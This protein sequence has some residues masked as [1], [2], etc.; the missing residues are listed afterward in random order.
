MSEKRHSAHSAAAPRIVRLPHEE[1]LM[2]ITATTSTKAHRPG[3]RQ[4]ELR[5][6][7]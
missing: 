5:L 7:R 3:G 4:P 6:G 1:H 2:I